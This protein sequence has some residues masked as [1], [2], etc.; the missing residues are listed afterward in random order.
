MADYI[1]KDILCQ[2]YIHID[3]DLKKISDR[4]LERIK[5][6]LVAYISQR[7][8]HFLYPETEVEIQ[9]DD[10]SIK[11]K[12]SVLGTI[13]ALYAG[14][15]NYGSFREGVKLIYSDVK[16][17]SEM[18]I[19]ESM[20]SFDA[21]SDRTIRIEARVGIIGS[22]NKIVRKLE[23]L[24]VHSG[25]MSMDKVIETIASVHSDIDK[26]VRVINNEDEK[27]LLVES[28]SLSRMEFLR[29]QGKKV[30]TSIPLSS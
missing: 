23:F 27:I 13:A 30:K 21:R 12:M 10:G 28:Y 22:L 17:L 15:A 29:N 14:I 24:E 4:D 2:A 1:K 20:Y 16:H 5:A 6:N 19:S 8:E 9:V 3:K 26:L 18:I 7:A 11:S 25:D